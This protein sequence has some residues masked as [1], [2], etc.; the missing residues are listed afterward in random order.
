MNSD[1]ILIYI[2]RL[3]KCANCY[4]KREK[5]CVHGCPLCVSLMR[6]WTSLCDVKYLKNIDEHQCVIQQRKQKS[7]T[8]YSLF[9]FGM[10]I[11]ECSGRLNEN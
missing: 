6:V 10:Y 2:Q 7:R 11:Y 1:F 9:D 5:K 4:E 3:D 8:E